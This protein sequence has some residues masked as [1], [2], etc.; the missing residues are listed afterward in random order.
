M[1]WPSERRRQG[2]LA[3]APQPVVVSSQCICTPVLPLGVTAVSDVPSAVAV[4]MA[5]LLLPLHW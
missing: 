5:G 4:M 1:S 2:R 3:L